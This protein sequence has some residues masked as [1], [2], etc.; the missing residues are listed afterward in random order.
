MRFA[1]LFVSSRLVAHQK[2]RL[3]LNNHD[4]DTQD[5]CNRRG[6]EVMDKEEPST[7]APEKHLLGYIN[8]EPVAFGEP[9]MFWV[10]ETRLHEYLG[11]ELR[12]LSKSNK[13]A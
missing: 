9:P 12:R 2:N 11:L 3:D 1:S 6:V 4:S 5:Y 8:R 7:A 13:G 10:D